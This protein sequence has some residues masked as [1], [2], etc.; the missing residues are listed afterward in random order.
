MVER[1]SQGDAEYGPDDAQ[2]AAELVQSPDPDTI[3][4]TP[5][6]TWDGTV[7]GLGRLR[8]IIREHPEMSRMARELEAPQQTSGTAE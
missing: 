7:D 1:I 4:G 5:T 6:D 8:Q 2:E 3:V